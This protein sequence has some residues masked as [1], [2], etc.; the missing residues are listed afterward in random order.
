MRSLEAQADVCRCGSPSEPAVSPASRH[1]LR[2]HHCTPNRP[3]LSRHF[4]K[5]AQ[6]DG[7]GAQVGR[8]RTPSSDSNPVLT[9][10]GYSDRKE[11]TVLKQNSYVTFLLL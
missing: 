3:A 9:S 2:L 4:S 5:T 6:S 8:P 11:G 1:F 7:S 10:Q